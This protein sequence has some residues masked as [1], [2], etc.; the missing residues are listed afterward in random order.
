LLK[1]NFDKPIQTEAIDLNLSG[2]RKKTR[3]RRIEKM[4][5][6]HKVRKS[7]RCTTKGGT[8]ATSALL[9]LS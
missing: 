5:K 9:G 3:P 4:Q 7:L 1:I 8:A 6:K 2:E